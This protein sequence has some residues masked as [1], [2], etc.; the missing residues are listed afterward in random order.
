MSG[1][2]QVTVDSPSRAEFGVSF[3]MKFIIGNNLSTYERLIVHIDQKEGFLI[4]GATTVVHEV[5]M[6]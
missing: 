5:R 1:S 4:A 3:C 6:S 2:F